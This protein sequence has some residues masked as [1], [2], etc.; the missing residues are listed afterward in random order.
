MCRRQAPPALS[1]AKLDLLI[2][3]GGGGGMMLEYL[4][5]VYDKE[6]IA[7][8]AAAFV[9]FLAAAATAPGAPAAEVSLMSAA[10]KAAVEGFVA[11]EMRADYA[12]APFTIHA[13]EAVAAAHPRR[14]ALE[15]GGEELSYAE[16]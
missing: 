12:E 10:D 1:K 11:G 14:V 3:I 4:A 2:N 13:F 15:F 9:Q 7:R 6:S 5:E 16:V 8:L